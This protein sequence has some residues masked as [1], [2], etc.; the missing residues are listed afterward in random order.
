MV[1]LTKIHYKG[2]YKIK[3][4]KNGFIYVIID[5]NPCG[6]FDKDG[7]QITYIVECD[8]ITEYLLIAD[9]KSK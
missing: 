2:I 5:P 4:F 3:H 1:H 7:C 8:T 9:K 6:V